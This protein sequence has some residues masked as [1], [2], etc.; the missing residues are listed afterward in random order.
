MIRTDNISFAF[1][2]DEPVLSGLSFSV[3]RGGFLGVIGPNGAG[4]TTLIR[5]LG[6]ALGPDSGTV[7]LEGRPLAQ[8]DRGE[9]ARKVA[10]VPQESTVAFPFT[11]MEI[12]LM[13]R[14][15][16]LGRF[17]FESAQ[18]IEK[19][20]RA[21][22]LTDTLR[23]SR[24]RLG[25]LSGGEKQRVIV[26]RALAQE[27]KLLL[28]DEPTTFL[29]LKHQLEIYSLL[30]KLIR[31]DGLTVIASSHDLN[32]AGMFCDRLLLLERGS[33][34][35]EGRPEE[36]LTREILSSVY[37]VPVDVSVHPR[38]GRP[39]VMPEPGAPG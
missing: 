31:E 18:D 17:S 4:K 28:L 14:A 24:R 36:V 23:F 3:E 8:Y 25:E 11:V 1:K 16:Y 38:T 10:V 33:R 12:V 15:P 29:D 7:F 22:T 32:L 21:M 26:A 27:P 2:P 34:A 19:A 39:L 6:R 37:D 20:G 9:L 13:G 5:L 30:K 35:I